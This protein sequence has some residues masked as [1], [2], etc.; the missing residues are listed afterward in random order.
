MGVVS[1]ALPR[2]WS[3]TRVGEAFSARFSQGCSKVSFREGG[4]FKRV[5]GVQLFEKSRPG[6]LEGKGWGRGMAWCFRGTAL[7]LI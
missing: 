2:V 7:G 1:W 4:L 3:A 5:C 6:G